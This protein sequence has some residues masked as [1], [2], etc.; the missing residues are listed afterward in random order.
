LGLTPDFWNGKRVLVTGNT[1]FKGAWLSYWLVRRG[2]EV[3]GLALAPTSDP[4]LFQTANLR[5]LVETRFCDIRDFKSVADCMRDSRCDVVFHL[6]AQ[7]L[8]R[9]SYLQPIYTYEANVLGTAHVLEAA[10]SCSQVR[11]IVCV[12]T[13]KCYENREWVWPYRENDAL[14][15]YDPYSS[16]KACAEI[17]TAAYARSFFSLPESAGVAT[18]RGGN[19]VGGGDWAE[20]RLV[21]DL[22]RAFSNGVVGIVRNPCSVRP[23]QYVL[24]A[25]NGYLLLAQRLYDE[26]RLYSEPWNFGP[27]EEWP[28]N[29]IADALKEAWGKGAL[30]EVRASQEA[31]H[32]AGLLK[33]DS[34]KARMRLAWAER[35][36]VRD[37]I[38]SV[39]RWYE[40]YY[41]G[42]NPRSLMD[43]ALDAFDKAGSRA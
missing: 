23:W 16:S 28:V 13:D 33:L 5:D 40:Q 15:G 12:T 27:A 31:P 19:V 36:C 1:G 6:A 32:E 35:F 17:V 10:R 2:A 43:E 11:A 18:A 39:A 24:D 22:V 34:S 8:V 20:D 42:T 41:R 14:G 37:V 7:P 38:A 3:K 26:P 4:N 25:L 21:P 30:W 9:E 29:A